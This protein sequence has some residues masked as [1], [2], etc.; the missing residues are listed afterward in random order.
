MKFLLLK[1][2]L[3]ITA[4]CSLSAFAAQAQEVGQALAGR[5]KSAVETNSGNKVRVDNV[6]RTP[7]ASVYE[8][9]SGNEIFYVDESGSYAFVDGRLVDLRTQRDLTSGRLERLQAVDFK[10]LPLQHAIKEVHGNG[11]RKMAIFEDP[12]CPICRVFHKFMAQ[13]DDV[14]IY[15]FMFPVIDPASAGLAKVAWCSNDRAQVWEAIM[16]GAR[17]QGRQD[18]DTRGLVAILKTGE[19]LQINNT[20]T[21]FLGNGKLLVGA[22]PPEQFVAELDASAN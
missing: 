6:A 8:I 20:P 19:K 4:L 3:I 10:E 16:N 21:V 14:T 11:K 1:R 2:T 18:C 15:K 5:I 22:T 9:T 7:I 13:L 12:N 17:P